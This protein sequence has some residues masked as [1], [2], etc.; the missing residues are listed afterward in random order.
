MP[1]DIALE[2]RMDLG[3][4]LENKCG[5]IDL[6]MI[7]MMMNARLILIYGKLGNPKVIPVN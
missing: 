3:L 4:P 1:M 5:V 6:Q 7:P 2:Q